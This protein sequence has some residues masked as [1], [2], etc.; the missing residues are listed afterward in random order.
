M[1]TRSIAGSAVRVGAGKVSLGSDFIGDGPMFSKRRY[2]YKAY[3]LCIICVGS[4]SVCAERAY[5][6]REIDYV[7]DLNVYYDVT[8][9]YVYVIP[10]YKGRAVH[11]LSGGIRRRDL[12]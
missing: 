11:G 12:I 10:P 7:Y 2:I 5:T 6:Q 8:I 1:V 3:S 4:R 9:K